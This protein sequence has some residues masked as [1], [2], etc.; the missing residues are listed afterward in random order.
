MRFQ[1]LSDLLD[2]F[3]DIGIPGVDCAVYINHEP[4]FRHSA[5]YSDLE[6][7]TPINGKE[8][9][10][11]Y[12]CTK[13]ITCAT[14]LTLLEKGKFLLTEPLY[15]YM[16]EF[17]TMYKENGEKAENPITIR[18]LFTMSAGFDYGIESPS[19]KKVIAE[20]NGHATTLDIVRAIANEPLYFEP[21]THWRYSLCHDV[22][23]GLVEVVSGKK[24][25]DYVKEVIFDPL[26]MKR[27]SFGPSDLNRDTLVPLY[28]FNEETNRAERDLIGCKYILTPEYES[29]GAGIVSCVD[30]YILFA[31]AMAN[32]G[33]AKNGNRI[34]A[35]DT[36]DL[37]RIN[38]LDQTAV[39]DMVWAQHAGYGYGLGVRTMIDRI[40]GGS[41][42]PI[43][44]FGWS[45]AAG[46]YTL[47]DPERRLAVYYAQH[48][49]KNKE[50]YT[51]PRMRNVLYACLGQE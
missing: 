27:S 2:S 13:V 26:G 47:I 18:D 41:I 36:I 38:C 12:S 34:L 21:G 9:Y 23:A 16:P 46:A 15:A 22:L 19:I 11:I 40:K 17:Q 50:P 43:G 7:K 32:G 3:I 44:E 25:G 6:A 8:T 30:D 51:H 20:K 31:D 37:M 24:F 48:M 5:G 39:R 35:S 45:G 33:V 10:F 49:L 1:Q 29:G 14:A 42:G 4:V 28:R